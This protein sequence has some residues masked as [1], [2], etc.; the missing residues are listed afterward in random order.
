MGLLRGF[1]VGP[2]LF[3]RQSSRGSFELLKKF[4]Y[5]LT[6][7]LIL[8]DV[9]T[10]VVQTVTVTPEPV[11]DYLVEVTNLETKVWT[12]P[13]IFTLAVALLAVI[14]SVISIAVQFYTWLYE[15]PLVKLRV[16]IIPSIPASEWNNGENF[17][18]RLA[19]PMKIRVSAINKGRVDASVGPVYLAIAKWTVGKSAKTLKNHRLLRELGLFPILPCQPV[20]LTPGQEIYTFLSPNEVWWRNDSKNVNLKQIRL[21]TYSFGNPVVTKLPK[22]VLRE[23]IKHKPCTKK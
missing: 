23:L 17:G 10:T 2:A 1:C 15:G 11:P 12:G 6:M 19:Q 14:V 4:R 3:A 5:V 22:T 13:V 7:P 8:A 9:V 18:V 21:V 20:S 16:S